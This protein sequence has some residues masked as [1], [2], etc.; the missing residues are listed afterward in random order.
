VAVVSDGSV[1]L[2][3]SSVTSAARKPHA[4]RPFAGYVLA[5]GL[6]WFQH[7]RLASFLRQAWSR[8]AD[9]VPGVVGRLQL[10]LGGVALFALARL[11]T[12]SVP[13]VARMFADLGSPPQ[14]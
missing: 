4:G 2:C 8:I 6:R 13:R 7:M 3:T 14:S 11:V 12:E 10:G 9:A 5:C 1:R